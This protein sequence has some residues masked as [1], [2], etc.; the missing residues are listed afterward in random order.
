MTR[1]DTFS[2]IFPTTTPRLLWSTAVGGEI[3]SRAVLA[4]GGRVIVG[5]KNK[6]ITVLDCATGAIVWSTTINYPTYYGSP[7]VDAD[8]NVY[9]A[10]WQELL[11]FDPTG[12]RRWKVSY[13]GNCQ[14]PLQVGDQGDLYL[15]NAGAVIGAP[16]MLSCYN[17]SDGSL[18]WSVTLT[19]N[20]AAQSA[21]AL[22]GSGQAIVGSDNGDLVYVQ[23]GTVLTTQNLG[24]AVR[25]NPLAVLD[26]TGLP[27]QLIVG[28]CSNN[29]PTKHQLFCFDIGSLPFATNWVFCP[30]STGSREYMGNLT[31]PVISAGG[32]VYVGYN[33]HLWGISGGQVRF[34]NSDAGLAG[35][36]AIDGQGNVIVSRERGDLVAVDLSGDTLW[37]LAQGG[38]GVGV[39]IDG[40]GNFYF[41]S[42]A[43]T[44][45]AYGA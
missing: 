21:P 6:K 29:D 22:L 26:R 23:N 30:S 34:Q 2:G 24:A 33:G 13:Q 31:S 20:N 9:V 38:Q 32:I 5:D 37:T 41:G 15:V 4:P 43:G 14:A 7:A 11:S 19:G 17:T 45:Y 12:A 16:S 40:S 10:A 39:A 1:L 28:T 8:G 25:C 36:I 3:G 42:K 18:K 35:P 44:V 27:T